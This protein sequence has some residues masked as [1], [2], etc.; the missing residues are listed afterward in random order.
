MRTVIAQAGIQPSQVA[1]RPDQPARDHRA[2]APAN[3]PGP[4]PRL[5]LAGPAHPGRM[6]EAAPAARGRLAASAHRAAL[7]TRTS[8]HP[9]AWLL[10]HVPGAL[11]LAQQ[12]LLA[13]GTV[14]SWLVWQI[15]QGQ[16]HATDPSNASRTS[17][18]T[19]ATAPGT[20]RC[21][22]PSTFPRACS[23]KSGPAP[24]T[25]ACARCSATPSPS[26]AWRVTKAAPDGGRCW[27]PGLAKN[28][29]GTGCFALLHT[30]AH[31]VSSLARACWPRPAPAARPSRP[32]ALPSK[33]ASSWRGHRAMAQGRASGWP[34]VRRGGGA[35]RLGSRQRRRDPGAGIR[36]TGRP[37][38]RPDVRA[39]ILGLSRVRPWPTSP[40]PAS[41]P[42]PPAE[43]RPDRRHEPLGG[44]TR[45]QCAARAAAW[46][47]ARP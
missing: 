36:R 24:A 3:R 39:A 11:A 13:F 37:H 26:P 18:G 28:T 2:A 35:G 23:Q 29:Y 17:C 32:T 27:R 33:A 30:G 46:T 19:C 4:A 34:L 12:G 22:R 21:C 43:L 20:P 38:W 25:S 45:E 40:G 14:D 6:R 16:V 44:G 8:G 10:N 41:R 1:A 9:L 5:G 31:A 42:W 47:A 15:T 7:G